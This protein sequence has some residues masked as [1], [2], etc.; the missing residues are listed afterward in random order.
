MGRI[1]AL[2][3]I[4][5]G[6]LTSHAEIETVDPAKLVV[7]ARSQVGVTLDYDPSY[8]AISY[9]GGDVPLESG[10]CCDVAADGTPFLNGIV[11]RGSRPNSRERSAGWDSFNPHIW[12]D[13]KDESGTIVR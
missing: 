4:C 13:V 7:A 1:L 8:R 12:A 3:C 11:L 5:F 10:V 6:I 2:L 9:P